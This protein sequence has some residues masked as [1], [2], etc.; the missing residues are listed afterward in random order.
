MNF[1]IK[2]ILLWPKNKAKN[3]RTID[4]SPDKVNVITGGSER[5]KSAVI[6]IVD[7][8]LG[9]GTCRIPTKHI[10]QYTDWFGVLFTLGSRELLLARRE[11]REEQVSGEMYMKEGTNVQIPLEL[12]SN[13][14]VT[15]VKNRLNSIANLSDIFSDDEFKSGFD[16]NPSFRDF[17][18]FLFQPQYIIANQSTLFYRA[19]SYEQREKLKNIFPYILNA[20]DNDYLNKRDELKTIDRKITA[21]EKE[22]DKKKKMIAKWLGQLRG[23]YTQAKELGLLDRHPYPTE[24]WGNEDYLKILRTAVQDNS[25][26]MI[27]NISINFLT[28]TSNRITEL[29]SNENNLAYQLNKLKHRQELL[30]RLNE[31]SSLYRNNLLN[32]KNRLVSTSWIT[33]LVKKNSDNAECP[34]CGSETT[35]ALDYLYS[36]NV[37][38]NQIIE[39][40]ERLSDNY[41]VTSGEYNKVSKE[42][43]TVVQELNKI[44]DELQ[45]LRI[46]SADS[47]KYL[48]TIN[49]IHQFIGKL[50][51]EIE[52]YDSLNDD[53]DNSQVLSDLRTRKEEL[54]KVVNSEVVNAKIRS[55]K[56]TIVASL[57]HYAD[58]FKVENR[59]ELIEFN[60][61]D[62]TLNFISPNGRKD[63]LYEIGSGHNYM[64]YHLST[65]L[66]FH[67][68]FLLSTDHP[69]PSFIFFDQ[70][71]QVYFPESSDSE[72]TETEDMSRVKKIFEALESAV[73]RTKGKLQII[74]LEHVGVSAWAG[75]KNIEKV[76][77]WRDGEDDSALIPFDWIENPL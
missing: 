71:T 10:K 6:S 68:F 60:H 4:F 52:N 62:L 15:D 55:A 29:T 11:P 58:I 72:I 21:I 63:A 13:F 50:N 53:S 44:R 28:E 7:Y 43:D 35:N 36:V 70:P 45:L 31:S 34:F 16:S 69:T 24:L 37:L 38:K 49:S 46:E 64:G 22:N 33:D 54:D 5:G 59:N 56:N 57:K 27:P 74:V 12:V 18:S 8:C 47:N 66:A 30:R 76:R 14:N 3:I 39:K 42:I 9:S 2:T 73:D 19:D 23:L 20:V 1:K 32:Q 25:S 51:A 61:K 77:R 48:H 41:S 17:T 40:E 75:F 67:E 26:D 65:L